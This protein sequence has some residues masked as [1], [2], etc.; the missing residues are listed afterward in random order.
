MPAPPP[1]PVPR[2]AED[3]AFAPEHLLAGRD[4]VA[5]DCGIAP[6]T[7]LSLSHWPGSGTPAAYADDTSALIV[8]RYLRDPPGADAPEVRL[9]TND[10]Y[11]EDGLFA[12]WMLL[13]RPA[14]DAP[15]RA[16]AIAASEAGDFHTWTDPVA[17]R[18]AIA[19][20]RM[21]ERRTTPFPE[22]G[23]ILNRVRDRDPA[24]D[25]YEVILPRVGGLL[26]DP[27]RHRMLWRD[28]WAQI[29]ADI[30]LLDAGDATVREEPAA[31][32]AIVRTPRRLHAMALYPRTRRMRVLESLPDGTTWVRHRY[33]TWVEYVSRPLSPRVDLVP[34]LPRLQELERRPGTW[35]AEDMRAVRPMLY[36][37]GSGHGP[38]PSS[39]EPERLAHELATYLSARGDG[40][41]GDPP[42]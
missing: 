30:A 19:A 8:D 40:R 6:G 12:L 20:M 5:V 1:T 22:V 16:L 21:A 28:E 9:I 42:A 32:L 41:G 35:A 17:A 13:E 18:T 26:A 37:R 7:V 14:E 11:D 4:H 25:L 2:V 36:L 38:A 27:D 15:E 3:A 23:R 24:G 31:D 29:E 39:I 34:L 10:H 33:E